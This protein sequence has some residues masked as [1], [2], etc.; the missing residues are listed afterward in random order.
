MLNIVAGVFSEGTPPAP[1]TSYES[2]A[3]STA[4][5]SS[6]TFTSIPSTFKHLQVRALGVFSGTVGAGFMYFN[7][8]NASG[9]YS[10]HTLHGDGSTAGA[11]AAANQNEG[12]FTAIGGTTSTAPTAMVMD[13]LDYTNTNKFKTTRHI[14][15]W[16]NNSSGYIEF[17]SNLWRSTS[18]ITSITFR[19]ANNFA[20][21]TQFALYGIKG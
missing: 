6:I 16:D 13:I 15:A 4:T 18:A 10:L 1:L 11:S 14:F 7:G 8:D 21:N 3:T 5:G 12:K 19:P 2:I 17:D 9:N 20:T